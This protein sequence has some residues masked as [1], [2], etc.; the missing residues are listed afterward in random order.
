MKKEKKLRS[1]KKIR[2][3]QKIVL[4]IVL[5]LMSLFFV[6]PL[7]WMVI[8]ALKSPND[9][10]NVHQFLPSEWLWSNFATALTRI[11]F[12]RY[13]G[14]S[15]FITFACIIGTIFSSSLAAYAFAKLR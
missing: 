15:L 4:H 10:V 12:I 6:F 13:F 1:T 5:F 3:V 14:N 7:L 9:M 11:P 2:I 8:T